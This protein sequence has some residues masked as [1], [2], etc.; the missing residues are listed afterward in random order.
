MS[1]LV[2]WGYSMV[3]PE[4]YIFYGMFLVNHTHFS[5]IGER[6]FCE[7]VGDCDYEPYWVV[8]NINWGESHSVK[9]YTIAHT[10]I[11]IYVYPM[12]PS[13]FLGSTWGMI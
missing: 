10:H 5:K 9:G 7:K 13:A 2:A 4:T 8:Q 12:D 3:V 11:Y 6:F 1:M